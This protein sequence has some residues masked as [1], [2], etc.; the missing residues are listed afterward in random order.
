MEFDHSLIKQV[1]DG[2]H[3][4]I[5]FVDQNRTIT[6]WNTGAELIAGYSAEE[7]VGR[8]CDDGILNHIDEKGQVLCLNN[9]PLCEAMHERTPVRTHAYMRHKRGHRVAVSIH[10][11]PMVI[12]NE[13]RGAVLA[14]IAEDNSH[15]S[16]ISNKEL[17]RLALYDT[18]TGLPNR[19]FID[20]YLSNQIR[21][22]EEFNLPFSIIMLD[23]DYFKYVND[24]FG[25]DVGDAVLKMVSK[26]FKNALRGSDFIGRWGG[27]EFLAIVHCS[28]AEDLRFIADKIRT[29]VEASEFLRAGRSIKITV[30]AGATIVRKG[31]SLEVIT[32]RADDALYAC[33]TNGR[34][35]SSIS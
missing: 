7:V 12:E 11:I 20:N 13:V 10:S 23:L 27:D 22:F 8:N 1:I 26:T 35:I 5:F 17:E 21:D 3:E 4:G 2:F 30:S 28:T 16:S 33:K 31:D 18:L 14:F 15:R 19:R 9:C 25:H 32:K 24:D 34:N 29:L 6:Y